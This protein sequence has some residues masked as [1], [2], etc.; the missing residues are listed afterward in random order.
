MKTDTKKIVGILL[1]LPAGL[2]VLWGLVGLI[3]LTIQDNPLLVVGVL[4]AASFVLG[5]RL[6][7]QDDKG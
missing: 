6:F 7:W 5:L 2:A 4:A 1:M 3:E